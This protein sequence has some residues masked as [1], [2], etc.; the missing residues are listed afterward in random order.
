[1]S[2][3]R[4]APS[5]TYVRRIRATLAKVWNA[6]VDPR[7]LLHWWGP[8]AGPALSAETDVRVGGA[9]RIS[10]RTMDGELHETRGEYL[11]LDPPKRLLMSWW[12]S[13]TPGVRS[14]VSI[15]I[16]AVHEGVEVTVKHDGF[17]DEGLR[18][19]HEQGWVTA[20]DKMAA[21]VEAQEEQEKT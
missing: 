17:S 13:D 6:F 12:L 4:N 20:I 2:P 5:L 3:P 10:F 7:E 16:V 21:H 11:D 18:V 1:M 9:F 15:S 14:R 8:D 19:T